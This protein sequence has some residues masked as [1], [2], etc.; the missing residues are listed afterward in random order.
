MKYKDYTVASA[1]IEFNGNGQQSLF[2]GKG[3]AKLTHFKY[4]DY[5]AASIKVD[6]DGRNNKS[7]LMGKGVIHVKK[8]VSKILKLD[9]AKIDFDASQK[10]LDLKGNIQQ[11]KIAGQLIDNTKLK[12]KGTI[13]NHHVKL[14]G[15]SKKGN[16]TITGNGSWLDSKWKGHIAKVSVKNTATGNWSLNKPVKINASQQ[17]FSVTK[18]CIMNPKRGQLCTD[19]HWDVKKGITSQGKFIRIPLSQLKQWLPDSIDLSGVVNGS[20]NINQ[21]KDGL[22]GDAKFYLPNHFVQ[23]TKKNG[24]K[25]TLAYHDGKI[26]L[27]FK[28][29]TIDVTT[30]LKIQK[31]GDLVTHS[32]ITLDTE[33]GRHRINGEVIFK[34]AELS[35]AQDFF[36]DITR[37]Q[38][39]IDSKLK[40]K[41]LLRSPEYSGE[42]RL[43]NGK[44]A[45]PDTG[46]QLS[47]INLLIETSKPNHAKIKGSLNMGSGQLALDGSLQITKL[48]NWLAELN[49][50]GSHLQFMN[51]HEIQAYASPDLH[52]K[53]APEFVKVSGHF[54]IPKA[55][56][57]LSELPETAIYESD[58][59]VFVGDNNLEEDKPLRI[60]PNV[61]IS[62]GNDIA[63]LGFGLNAKLNGKFHVSHNRMNIVSRGSLK[64]KKGEYRAY[65]Q[66][67]TIEHGVLV[68]NGP[69]SNPGLNIRATRVIRESNRLD[70]I[71]VGINLAGTLQKP[72]SSIF[73]DPPKSQSD[74]F[75]YL[76]TGQS[77]SNTS[78]DQAQLL[79]QA[80]RSLGIT[81]GS[82]MLNKISGTLG[83][84][85]LNI[86]TY[87]DYRRNKLQLGKKL[88]TDLYI[89]YITGLFDTFHKIAVDYKLSNKWSLQ[90]ES[91]EAQGLDFIY[92]IDAN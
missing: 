75:S 35:W 87:S 33:E 34:V 10:S 20:Y 91:G 26:N 51:T 41:G 85:D 73:S 72:K 55:L 60:I 47:N 78:G 81:S 44:L 49:L 66:R 48:N 74:A 24:T 69:F 67:L 32:T 57:R 15:N 46:T 31:R 54:H 11:L 36:P 53:I 30:K 61:T 5:R 21:K 4:K 38:G 65:G 84:D 59:V 90:A 76:I 7:L 18:V 62:L 14:T 27:I 64:I 86:I 71:K 25:E 12:A 39:K 17:S 40:Y 68:F 50:K 80:V 42:I 52:L 82:T 63:F 28:G 3:K 13:E 58:D 9:S 16:F 88:G 77:L 70:N 6:F 43:K 92:N 45:I 1:D 22:Y 23:F 8:L 29:K 89:K 2:A 19:T 83:L 56:I 37:L 79:V